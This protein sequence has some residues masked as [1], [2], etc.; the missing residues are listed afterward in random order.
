[1]PKFIDLIGK[2][3]E[4]LIVIQR[5][6]DDKH[7]NKKWLCE[8]DCQTKTIIRGSSLRDGSTKSCG[9]LHRETMT[10]HG[11]RSKNETSKTYDA[12]H[13]MIQRCI[14]QNNKNWNN[15]GGR[16]IVV[17]QRWLKFENFLQDMREAPSGYQIDRADN[18]R[19]YYKENCR[20]V[21]AKQN[22]RNRRNNHMITFGKKTQ[23]LTSWSEETGVNF[24]TLYSRLKCNWSIKKTLTTPVKQR[25]KLL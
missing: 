11:H 25:K 22:S 9:C 15:Y 12:W 8:C 21:T 4:R 7:K 17:C 3:F 2:R 6:S 19:G 18:D 5:V 23:C 14:N 1:M 13:G 16:G 10:K 24:N 20:W